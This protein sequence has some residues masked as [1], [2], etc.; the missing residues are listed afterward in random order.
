MTLDLERFEQTALI[1]EPFEYL[2]LP[3]FVNPGA[4]KAII[5]D[6]PKVSKP[7]SFPITE[8]TFGPMF[9]ELIDDLNSP[10]VRAA[11]E[12]KFSVDLTGRPTMMNV[13]GR[14][15]AQDGNIH[16]DSKTK[17][18]TL[19]VYLNPKWESA[20]G[21]LRLLRSWSNLDEVI[22]EVSPVEGTLIAF[23]PSDNSWHG[24]NRF[25]GER[26]VI[27]FNWVT[28]VEVVSRERRRRRSAATISKH[29]RSMAHRV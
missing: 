4:Q 6:Y 21:R 16:T 19:L 9:K 10:E 2:V 13:R 25:V 27:Q 7:G 17:I 28:S 3:E 29:V 12:R 1:R 22:V 24:H 23:K 8:V 11:F 20:G 14:C 18:L 26:R 15:S 5:D